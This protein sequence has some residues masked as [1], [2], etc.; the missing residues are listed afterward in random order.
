MSSL[1]QS[2]TPTS[3]QP[4]CCSAKNRQQEQSADSPGRKTRLWFLLG[5]SVLILLAIYFWRPL[6]QQCLAFLLLRS[7]GPSDEVLSGAV[8]KGNNPRSLLMTL[9]KTQRIPHRR[10]VLSYLA[11]VSTSN[12]SLLQMMETVVLEGTRDPD[13]E[14]R[15]SAFAT[16]ARSKHPQLRRLALEQLADVDPA[17]R[18]LGLQSLRSSATS[19]EVSIAVRLLEDPEPRVV[20]AAALVLRQATGEDFGIRSTHALPQFTGIDTNPPPP[21]DL[22]AIAKGVR[23]WR[24]WWQ[25]HQAD[26]PASPAIPPPPA[27]ISALATPD[28]TLR[29][30]AGKAFR[31][32]DYRGKSVLL[33]FWN[34]AVPFS[35]DSL[36]SL[37]N[38]QTRHPDSLAVLGISVPPAASCA[39]E[40][41]HG[42]QHGGEQAHHH[43]GE[44]PGGATATEHMR[45]FVRD[46]AT[47]LKLNYPMLMD[48]KEEMGR[49]FK[50]ENV[51]G[52][53]LID[54]D[55]LVR[56]RFVGIRSEA[57]LET[58]IK[59]ASAGIPLAGHAQ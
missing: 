33:V 12:P 41:E 4:D 9:W 8:E 20:V 26:Y 17:V 23:Q 3:S 32:S 22:P 53:V 59:E 36:Q 30:S 45:C 5:S 2:D 6:Q 55:G 48:T 51:P 44:S 47:R 24:E 21:P 19:N 16:L 34:W 28:F 29:D 50:I 27:R 1:P 37:K 58:M 43:H 40:D 49:R 52:Y 7:E 35:L 15:Q 54:A 14:T 39:D 10:F 46:A 56:R 31:L 57:I 13:V 42:Q 38:V 11:Q 25:A 18:L